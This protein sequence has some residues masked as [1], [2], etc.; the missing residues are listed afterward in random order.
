MGLVLV[1]YIN[2]CLVLARQKSTWIYWLLRLGYNYTTW[3]VDGATPMYWFIMA[4]YFSPPFGSGGSSHLLSPQF[5]VF[6]PPCGRPCR[7]GGDN[8]F[9][10]IS[11]TL[12]SRES[13]VISAAAGLYLDLFLGGFLFIHGNLRVPTPQGHPKK[14][15][16]K[17]Q[18]WLIVS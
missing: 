16:P 14:Q 6:F 11:P 18:W 10:A 13:Q 12:G 17:G 15:G 4:L 8:W 7:R 2:Q 5:F 3:K 9:P 1:Q